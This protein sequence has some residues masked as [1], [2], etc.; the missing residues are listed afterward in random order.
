MSSLLFL[1]FGVATICNC[2]VT[3]N[4]CTKNKYKNIYY[5]L[6]VMTLILCVAVLFTPAT[7]VSYG[8]LLLIGYFLISKICSVLIT[9]YY[10]GKFLSSKVSISDTKLLESIEIFK[11]NLFLFGNGVTGNKY[12]LSPYLKEAHNFK[13]YMKVNDA[14]N[15]KLEDLCKDDINITPVDYDLLNSILKVVTE[16]LDYCMNNFLFSTDKNQ[17]DEDLSSLVSSLEQFSSFLDIMQSNVEGG[18]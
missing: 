10:R 2:V 15:V 16:A 12:S 6:L 18:K 13:E 9:N 4:K 14:I 1:Y 8:F 7:N 5:V 11:R 17:V 3:I